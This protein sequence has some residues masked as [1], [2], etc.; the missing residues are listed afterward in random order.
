MKKKCVSVKTRARR[1]LVH[2]ARSTG[3]KCAEGTTNNE[4]NDGY[5][6]MVALS[7]SGSKQVD[8]ANSIPRCTH[9]QERYRGPIT[10]R[11]YKDLLNNTWGALAAAVSRWRPLASSI[12][13][14][15]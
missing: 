13:I 5:T 14:Y 6:L 12:Y 4:S 2:S 11:R 1:A 8:D 3:C 10:T 7:Q 9:T 15:I